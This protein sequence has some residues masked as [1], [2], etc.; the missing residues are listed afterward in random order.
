MSACANQKNESQQEYS[1]LTGRVSYENPFV[2]FT[3]RGMGGSMFARLLGTCALV[4]VCATVVGAQ[5]N[6]TGT[7]SGHVADPDG[8][9]VPAATITAASPLLHCIR[10][11]TTSATADY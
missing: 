7:L 10:T 9:A 11:S 4:L 3:I 1:R 6:P 8:L 5:G 2:S